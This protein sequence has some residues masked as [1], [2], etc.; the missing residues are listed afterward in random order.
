MLRSRGTRFEAAAVAAALGIFHAIGQVACLALSQIHTCPAYA[1]GQC[2]E[3]FSISCTTASPGRFTSSGPAA[4]ARGFQD[5]LLQL[6]HPGLLPQLRGALPARGRDAGRVRA[7]PEGLGPGTARTSTRRWSSTGSW[8]LV[9][10]DQG[11][12]ASVAARIETSRRAA[13]P[14]VESRL[15][16]A[17]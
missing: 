17:R 15:Q 1:R 8:G 10:P 12:T 5:A 13:F 4:N 6:H 7:Q 9:E 2:L 3:F 16:E 14:M 11:R